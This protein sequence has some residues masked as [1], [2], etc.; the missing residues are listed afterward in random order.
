MEDLKFRVKNEKHSVAIQERLFELGYDWI[1]GGKKAKNIQPLY[2]FCWGGTSGITYYTENFHY[3]PYD[4][5]NH[6]SKEATLDDL[7]K[8]KEGVKVKLNDEYT[9]IIKDDVV[10]IGCQEFSFSVIKKL[11]KEIKNNKDE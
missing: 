11:Y 6:P 9:A 7:Y 4:F 2:L 5:E 3:H 1:V 10:E 8:I